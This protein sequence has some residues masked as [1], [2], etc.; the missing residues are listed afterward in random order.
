MGFRFPPF[1]G[2]ARGG[3]EVCG[4][5]FMRSAVALRHKQ[6]T[7]FGEEGGDLLLFLV[8]LCF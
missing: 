5:G 2:G 4:S 3:D 7:A 6:S 8:L 1:E